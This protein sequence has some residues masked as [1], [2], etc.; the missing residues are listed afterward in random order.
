MTSRLRHTQKQ[1]QGF[2]ITEIC[3]VTIYARCKSEIVFR[4]IVTSSTNTQAIYFYF[5]SVVIFC[6]ILLFLFF[7][8]LIVS[9][10]NT[11][12]GCN[13]VEANLKRQYDNKIDFFRGFLFFCL[14][15][16]ISA[17]VMSQK[18]WY[19]GGQHVITTL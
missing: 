13:L 3:C 2:C 18:S 15:E 8:C 19:S 6:F 1:K 5:P 16:Y 12:L 17:Y 14:V 9:P 11:E 4:F 10:E 7:F